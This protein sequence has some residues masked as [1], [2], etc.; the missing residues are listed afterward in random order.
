MSVMQVKTAKP[1]LKMLQQ[2]VKSL[3]AEEDHPPSSSS[4]AAP[5]TAESFEWM[6]KEQAYAIVYLVCVSTWICV[7]ILVIACKIFNC[8]GFRLLTVLVFFSQFFLHPSSPFLKTVRA[9]Y[10]VILLLQLWY[11]SS[12]PSR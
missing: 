3:S 6:T 10:G 7:S 8:S 4:P 2:C 1:H 12:S 11:E 5:L 9:F